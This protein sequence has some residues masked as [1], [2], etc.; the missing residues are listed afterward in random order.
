MVLLRVITT[1]GLAAPIGTLV[2]VVTRMG[3]RGV[4]KSAVLRSQNARV[5]FYFGAPIFLFA[6]VTFGWWRLCASGNA[7]IFFRLRAMELYS[8]SSPTPAFALA[9][10]ALCC[11]YVFHLKRYALTGLARPR[12]EME[13]GENPT[14]FCD[15]FIAAYN[16]ICERVTAPWTL[17]TRALLHRVLGPSVF[18]L[19]AGW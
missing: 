19:V 13:R 2:F 5:G 9:A 12:L 16:A 1:A 14:A 17:S 3:D 4:L 15:R 7:A 11:V 8:G 10:A 18:V 6:A